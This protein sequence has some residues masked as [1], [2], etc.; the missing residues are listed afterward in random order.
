MELPTTPE[1]II[2]VMRDSAISLLERS[3]VDV[4]ATDGLV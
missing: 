4:V 3:I 2:I 1:P